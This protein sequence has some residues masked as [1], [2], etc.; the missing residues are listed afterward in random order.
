MG[1]A[2]WPAVQETPHTP[3]EQRWPA[4]QAFPQVPQFCGSVCVLVQKAL[5]PEPHAFGVEAGQPQTPLVQ[6]WPAGQTFP[7]VPQLAASV[8]VVAQ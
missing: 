3:P 5:A 8:V 2:V 6:V 4:G 1:Q 7:Q